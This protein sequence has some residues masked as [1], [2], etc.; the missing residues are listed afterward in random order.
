MEYRDWPYQ[1][2]NASRV[3]YV[4][5]QGRSIDKDNRQ[6]VGTNRNTI[7]IST[8]APRLMRWIRKSLLQVGTV[9]RRSPA[10]LGRAAA[11]I[12]LLSRFYYL[13]I[14]YRIGASVVALDRAYLGG[15]P[16]APLWPIKLL[17]PVTG[18]GWL[19]SGTSVTA[20]GLLFAISAA[21]F[22]RVLMW[23]LGTFLY[24]LLYVALRNSYGS[25]NHGEHVILLISFT[26]LFLPRRNKSHRMTRENVLSCLAVFWFTQGI[27]L[28][29]YT[30]AGFWKIWN[31][32]LEVLSLDAMTRILLDRALLEV[33]HLPRLLPFVL[34]H[35]YLAQSMWWLTLYIEVFALLVVFRPHLHRPFGVILMLFHVASDWLMNIAFFNNILMI[36]LFLVLSPLAPARFSLSGVVQSLPIVG[37]PFRTSKRLRS[38]DRGGTPRQVWLIYDGE[39]PLCS[40]YAQ[41]LNLKQSVEELVLVDARQGG[42]VVEEVRSL[43]HDLNDGM[44]VK[45]DRRYFVGHQALNVL[46]LLSENRGVFSKFN[47]LVFSSPL[48]ARLAYPLLKLGRW[49]L[50]TL[51]GVAPI[52]HEH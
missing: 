25:I 11:D 37:I 20:A 50:L 24:L 19:A 2:V 29:P 36:G 33:D 28:L 43:P 34:Q 7:S 45:I 41:Y 8:R 9:E 51:K 5:G 52:D 6:I 17:Q 39:C 46:A 22:P 4:A 26:L 48:V 21:A 16:T 23:R 12:I 3:G 30:L 38:S 13:F 10:D 27:L 1:P 32:R 49:L 14:A 42:P 47:R 18:V 31:S 40:N 35:G 44:V 15:P